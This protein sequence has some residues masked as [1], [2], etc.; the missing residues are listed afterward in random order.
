MNRP[1]GNNALLAGALLFCLALPVAAQ[2]TP[3]YEVPYSGTLKKIRDT[4]VVRIGFREN[5]PPF[6]F[7]APDGKPVGYA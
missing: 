2:R 5:S 7:R 6:A 4:G 3:A 1:T